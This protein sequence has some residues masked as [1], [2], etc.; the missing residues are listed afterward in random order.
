MSPYTQ[1]V[2]NELSFL[3][4]GLSWALNTWATWAHPI[5]YYYVFSFSFFIYSVTI[6]ASGKW[7]F[8]SLQ[9]RFDFLWTFKPLIFESLLVA[10]LQ[11]LQVT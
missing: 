1:L 8:I 6:L 11:L 3:G 2:M 4:L 7:E 5:H 10:M 9:I